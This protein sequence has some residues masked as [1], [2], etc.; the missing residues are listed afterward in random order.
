MNPLATSFTFPKASASASART[1][2]EPRDS[3]RETSTKDTR[4]AINSPASAIQVNEVDRLSAYVDGISVTENHSASSS[5][6]PA[7]EEEQISPLSRKRLQTQLQTTAKE[8]VTLRHA[9][10]ALTQRLYDL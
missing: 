6:I 8:L 2:P 3:S 5:Y 9:N 7:H 4:A 1:D 10:L